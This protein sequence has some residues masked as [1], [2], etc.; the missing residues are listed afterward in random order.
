MRRSALLFVLFSFAFAYIGGL[1][2]RSMGSGLSVLQVL[3]PPILLALNALSILAGLPFSILFD[4]LLFRLYG[5]RYLI[6][7]PLVVAFASTLQVAFL[8]TIGEDK[9]AYFLLSRRVFLS[10]KIARVE[11]LLEKGLNSLFLALFIRAVPVLPFAAGSIAIAALP[12][13]L[14]NVFG[15]SATGSW[16]YYLLV[17]VGFR[18]GFSLDSL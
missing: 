12:L 7:W 15:M 2:I 10:K 18:I 14:G 9:F 5:F 3:P 4:L 6:Y 11:A 17:F 8:R 13:S 1:A 16:L